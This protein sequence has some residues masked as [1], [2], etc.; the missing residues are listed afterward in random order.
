MRGFCLREWERLAFGTEPGQIPEPLAERLVAVAGGASRTAGEVLE[1]HRHHIR[2]RGVVGV[3]AAPGVSLEILPKIDLPAGADGDAAVR[4]RLVHM[5]AVALDLRIDTGAVTALSW[6]NETLLDLLIRIFADKLTEALRRGMPRRYT[7]LQDDLPALRGRLDVTRQFTTHAVNP[8]RLAC[9]FDALGADIALNQILKAALTHLAR[10]T[11]SGAL[12]GRLRDLALVYAEIA[13]VAPAALRWGDV[14]LD[15]TNRAWGELLSLAKLFLT[16]RYQTTAQ[17]AAQGTALMFEMDALFEDYIGRLIRRA[18]AGSG[19]SVTLQG[20]GLYCLNDTDTG[21]GLFRTRPDIL[22]R[23]EGRVVQVIDTKWKR[24]AAR[25]DEPKQG[26]SQADVYQ[27]MAY[28]Q[29]YRAPRV[30]LLYPH[31][32]G[33]TT[34]EGA[35]ARFTISGHDTILA[36]ASID[37]GQG[38]GLTT[39]LRGLLGEREDSPNAC[40][41]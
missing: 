41:A 8:A 20:G 34:P 7:G 10:L 16:N 2:A 5:L 37:V 9:R 38:A 12:R 18:L 4:R 26:V 36:T 32:A 15:R 1:H 17:G 40:P 13:D 21:R 11:R 35:Q 25:I 19:V 30:T 39:R 23:R 3:L 31:H 22:I 6:Q 29:L 28:A 27:M 24:I 33:L 14:G